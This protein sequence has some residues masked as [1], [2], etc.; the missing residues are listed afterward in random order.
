MFIYYRKNKK[1]STK[2][3]RFQFGIRAHFSRGSAKNRAL[4]G[5][6]RR[7]AAAASHPF[8]PLRGPWVKGRENTVRKI[9][10]RF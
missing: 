10:E 3:V 7:F 9:A 6:G 5:F 1:Y 2:I 8:N 4:R